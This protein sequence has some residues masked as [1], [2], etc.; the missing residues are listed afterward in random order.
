[1]SSA[2]TGE[3][4]NN[5]VVVSANH[6]WNLGFD[7]NKDK[8]YRCPMCGEKPG[9]SILK[10]LIRYREMDNPKAMRGLSDENHRNKQ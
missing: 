4:R 10:D 1:V 5:E 9:E 7:K 6:S 2:C 3:N 8:I